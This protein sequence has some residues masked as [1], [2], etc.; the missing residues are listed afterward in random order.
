MRG[1]SRSRDE[2]VLLR[3]AERIEGGGLRPD[4]RVMLDLMTQSPDHTRQAL[5]QNSQSKRELRQRFLL[6]SKCRPPQCPEM[7][8]GTQ[9]TSQEEGFADFPAKPGRQSE[10]RRRRRSADK[11]TA[12]SLPFESIRRRHS[13]SPRAV[14]PADQDLE[15]KSASKR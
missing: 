4:S 5:R 15:P 9:A 14:C 6:R 12:V 10:S 13:R 3:E 8:F 2:P 1:S 11:F 7:R